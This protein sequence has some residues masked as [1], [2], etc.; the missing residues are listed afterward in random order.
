G[1]V[2]FGGQAVGSPFRAD[3][4]LAVADSQPESAPRFECV[5]LFN[6]SQLQRAA[7]KI[8]SGLFITNRH[9]DLH[10]VDVGNHGRTLLNAFMRSA[11]HAL[12]KPG[13]I[14]SRRAAVQEDSAN[15]PAATVTRLSPGSRDLIRKG[16]ESARRST[17]R[18]RQRP[19]PKSA[20]DIR[21]H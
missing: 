15:V 13:V 9:R 18:R 17:R 12:E 21:S 8:T 2:R 3:M 20:S 10:M 5:G 11:V 16:Y 6:F 7:I 19:I 4:D 14:A 1:D